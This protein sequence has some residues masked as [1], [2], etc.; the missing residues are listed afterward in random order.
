[1]SVESVESVEFV[2]SVESAQVL[3]VYLAH[4]RVDFRAFLSLL[5]VHAFEEEKSSR[6]Y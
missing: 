1:M 5:K 2:E 4:L 6:E 3:Q